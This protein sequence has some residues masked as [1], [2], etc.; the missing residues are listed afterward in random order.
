MKAEQDITDAKVGQQNAFGAHR[1]V[2]E[3]NI[4]GLEAFGKIQEAGRL[5]PGSVYFD[6]YY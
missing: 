3:A 2:L 6:F 1:T 4:I 5:S